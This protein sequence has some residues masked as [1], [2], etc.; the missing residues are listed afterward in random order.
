MVPSVATQL[1]G[2]TYHFLS[3]ALPKRATMEFPARIQK[4]SQPAQA[5]HRL[6]GI[7]AVSDFT[8]HSKGFGFFSAATKSVRCWAALPQRKSNANRKNEKS[9]TG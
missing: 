7:A 1:L 8:L 3:F 2:F 9:F 5:T 6:D 4:R